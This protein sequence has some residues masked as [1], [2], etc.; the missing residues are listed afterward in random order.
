MVEKY[1]SEFD[2]ETA[3]AFAAAVTN[4]LFGNEPANE[5]GQVFL[6]QNRTQVDLKIRE[7]A[8]NKEITSIISIST[9][10][11][12]ESLFLKRGNTDEKAKWLVRTSKLKDASILLPAE[13]IKIPK[14][15]EDFLRIAMDFESWV[16]QNIQS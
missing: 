14:S 5:R 1:K 8:G 6:D 12:G 9:Y 7:L 15:G 13:R 10:L 3:S 11:E 2:K 16:R 4:E